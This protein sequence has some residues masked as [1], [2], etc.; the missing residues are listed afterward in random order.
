[1]SFRLEQ[2][3]NLCVV[4]WMFFIPKLPEF[5]MTPGIGLWVCIES[6]CR[7]LPSGKSQGG[8]SG[9]ILWTMVTGSTERGD[10]EAT[11]TSTHLSLFPSNP[12]Q[13]SPHDPT[14][15]SSGHNGV[16]PLE[17]WTKANPSFFQQHL[18]QQEEQQSHC[19]EVGLLPKE[20]WLCGCWATSLLEEWWRIWSHGLQR[21]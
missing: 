2:I 4:R 3:C 5:G 15:M 7:G 13:P 17:L 9:V 19:Q 20:G 16:W 18:S 1:M 6:I 11:N 10:W 21:P 14:A 8:S 12:L